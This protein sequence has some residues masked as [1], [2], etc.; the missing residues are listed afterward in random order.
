MWPV[1]TLLS[2]SSVLL[3]L[4]FG[5]WKVI[6]FLLL[7]ENQ[8]A[9]RLE[10]AGHFSP[11]VL[12]AVGVAVLYCCIVVF[13]S[14]SS[15]RIDGKIQLWVWVN[16]LFLSCVAAFTVISG[17]TL[18]TLLKCQFSA[19]YTERKLLQVTQVRAALWE[20][21][22][23]FECKLTSSFSKMAELFGFAPSDQSIS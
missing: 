17:G 3:I 12:P 6:F 8:Y 2:S 9:D 4:G 13:F 1:I 5:E 11:S 19:L 18:V 7:A 14:L 15:L 10:G 20:C 23:T 22:P 16:S 21:Q